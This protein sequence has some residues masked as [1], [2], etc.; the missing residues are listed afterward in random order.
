MEYTFVIFAMCPLLLTSCGNRDEK[1]TKQIIG[2]WTTTDSD[3]LTY[4]PNGRFDEKWTGTKNNTTKSLAF[5][6]KWAVRDGELISTLTNSSS[7]GFTNIESA[8]HV[9]HFNIIAVDNTH[10]VLELGGETNVWKRIK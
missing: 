5:Q 6:G 9:D 3:V 1:L 8:G 10:L 2:T 7:Q 4:A